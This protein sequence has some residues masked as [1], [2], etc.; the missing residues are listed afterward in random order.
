MGAGDRDATGTPC[1]AVSRLL[2]LSLILSRP[3]QL[4]L[5]LL[6]SG[7][8]PDARQELVFPALVTGQEHSKNSEESRDICEDVLLLS[9]LWGRGNG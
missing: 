2:P 9:S 6:N 4:L 8:P 5:P 1:G 3:L 7:V